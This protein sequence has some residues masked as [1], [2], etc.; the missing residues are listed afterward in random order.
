MGT[1]KAWES[2]SRFVNSDGGLDASG[3]GVVLIPKGS[4]FDKEGALI[5]PDGWEFNIITGG[6]EKVK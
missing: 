4:K 1:K 5:V 6:Y 3:E 2:D